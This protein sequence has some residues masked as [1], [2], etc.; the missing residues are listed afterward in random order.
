[1]KHKNISN[2]DDI[3]DS[4]DVIARIE[5]LEAECIHWV[6]GWNQPGYMPDAEPMGFT[7]WED[8]RDALIETIEE[9][10]DNESAAEYVDSKL[11]EEQAEQI[12]AW[13][14]NIALLHDLDDGDEF[15]NTAGGY[16]FWIAPS[17]DDMP[18][19]SDDAAELKAL[20]DLRDEAEGSPD[21]QYG[22]TLIRD[23]YFQEYAQELAEDIGAVNSDAS[24]PNR[25]IDWE[26]AARE[27]QIDY[28]LVELDGVD[29]WIRS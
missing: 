21:W 6:A 10:I 3:I 9:W 26:Q 8:A 4:R 18:E 14:R 11:A 12:A 16:A 27:L 28:T 5:K 13:S 7:E 1:M 24:W 17:D 2:S 23:S 22:E 15:T 19:D 20:R 25:C 29:Y